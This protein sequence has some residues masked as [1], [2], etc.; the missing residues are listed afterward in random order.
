MYYPLEHRTLAEEADHEH[1]AEDD[2]AKVEEGDRHPSPLD[3][4]V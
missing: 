3:V 1:D 2:H 4:V